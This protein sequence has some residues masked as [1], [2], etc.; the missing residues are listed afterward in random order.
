VTTTQ[1]SGLTATALGSFT[2]T[3][4]GSLAV[5][6]LG[7]ALS[8]DPN[9]RQVGPTDANRR[10]EPVRSWASLS[11]TTLSNFDATQIAA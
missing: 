1:L 2:P 10:S 8:V 7:G 6:Q 5:T 9:L 3:Q 11:T 4:I